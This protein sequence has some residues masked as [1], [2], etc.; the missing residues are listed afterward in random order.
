[1]SDVSSDQDGDF[2]NQHIWEAE[3]RSSRWFT[4]GWTLQE[5][6]APTS[7]EF[8]SVQGNRLGDK[9]SLESQIHEIT[10]IPI[11]ALRGDPLHHFSIEE[12]MEWTKGR[13]TTRKEDRAYCLQGI[14]GVFLSPIYGEGDHAFMRLEQAIESYL[15][16]KSSCHVEM[17]VNASQL[18]LTL[19]NS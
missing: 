14:F 6:L 9:R 18:R 12:R 11:Q 16:G 13:I 2:Y 17:F 19:R 15:N 5:L 8:F 4:R 1:M 3:F 10:K 7:V